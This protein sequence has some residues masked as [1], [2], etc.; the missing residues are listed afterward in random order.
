MFFVI[1]YAFLAHG[2]GRDARC[3]STTGARSR[4][5]CKPRQCRPDIAT[6]N[7]REFHEPTLS[8]MPR[9]VPHRSN[10]HR[11]SLRV[12]HYGPNAA[13]APLA[14]LLILPAKLLLRHDRRQFFARWQ[15][16][17]VPAVP[18]PRGSH[19]SQR[20]VPWLQSPRAAIPHEKQ[21]SWRRPAPVRTRRLAPQ[22]DVAV[23][24]PRFDRCESGHCCSILGLIC[25]SVA[26]NDVDMRWDAAW[27][28]A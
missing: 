3:S 26:R 25:L 11:F 4:S 28:R 5:S 24:E 15:G 19:A 2:H 17:P 12:R 6:T 16:R 23:A 13:K 20:S 1:V 21:I 10:V 7:D 14:P 8:V 22:M 9:M 18:S 27:T